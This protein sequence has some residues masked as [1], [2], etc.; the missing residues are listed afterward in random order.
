MIERDRL[1]RGFYAGIGAGVLQNILSFVA[2]AQ[3]LTTLRMADWS[4]IVIFGKSG[5]FSTGEILLGLV[6]HI[7]WSGLLG[8]IFVY[9]IPY[10][11][12][13]HFTLKGLLFGWVVWFFIYGVSLLYKVEPTMGLPLKTPISDLVNA[14]IY[15]LVLVLILTRI[16]E[17]KS[18]EQ[19][20]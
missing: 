3:G 16:T 13:Q 6:G 2:Y 11:N 9:L 17:N 20:L 1:T 8:I 4:A 10:I 5:P 15:G 14:S 7:I 18:S 12:H 19:K